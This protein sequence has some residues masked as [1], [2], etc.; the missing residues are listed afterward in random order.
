[1]KKI[2]SKQMQVQNGSI[3]ISLYMHEE[4][5]ISYSVEVD[6]VEWLKTNNQTH[7]IVLH[8][9]MSKHL[10]EYMNYEVI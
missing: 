7:A 9:M 2:K 8:E 1:M 5:E 3:E 10:T 6:G 4:N